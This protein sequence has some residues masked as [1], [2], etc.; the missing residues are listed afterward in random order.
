MSKSCEE[1]EKCL[2]V[3]QGGVKPYERLRVVCEAVSCQSLPTH[4]LSSQPVGSQFSC[5]ENRMRFR[6]LT[7]IEIYWFTIMEDQSMVDW[8]I[9][10]N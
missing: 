3:S 9:V 4:Y 8:C 1:V 2:R 5:E 6:E 7:A 10:M